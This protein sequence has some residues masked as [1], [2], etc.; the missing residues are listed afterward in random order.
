MKATYFE[1]IITPNDFLEIFSSFILDYTNEA[2][3]FATIQDN[4]QFNSFNLNLDSVNTESIIIRTQESPNEVIN[5]LKD[6]ALTLS[7]RLD[8]QI[9]FLYHTRELEN[10]DWIESYK[11][12][13][14][15][16]EIGEFYI[17]P[18][19]CPNK[20]NKKNIIIDPALAFGSGHHASTFMCIELL[21]TIDLKN[22]NLGDIGCGSGILG[23][24]SCILGANVVA[25]DVDEL[26]IEETKKNFAL[27][28][29]E[30]KNIFLGSINSNKESGLESSFLDSSLDVICANIIADVIIYLKNDF[31]RVLKQ[32]G[33]LI[34]SGIVEEKLPLV[35]DIFSDFTLLE[36][37]R[38]D[39]WVA[40]KLQKTEI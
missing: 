37:K 24:I 22:K 15:P 8:K 33:I 31:K 13:I 16:L 29:L 34:L 25:C 27:N 12:S 38:K 32:N 10:K 4:F 9:G 2:I 30:A 21:Q 40:L 28:N 20:E 6:F 14:T 5:N 1:T 17:R 23:I 35:L 11:S 19:W 18:S 39:E 26:A 3:E 36:S 7:E